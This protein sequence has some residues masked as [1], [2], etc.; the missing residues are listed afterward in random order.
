ML[1]ISSVFLFKR[2]SFLRSSKSFRTLHTFC[3]KL[4]TD[5]INPR[6]TESHTR[7]VP[8][9]STTVDYFSIL[10]WSRNQQWATSFAIILQGVIQLGASGVF[11][12]FSCRLINRQ[13]RTMRPL[14]SIRAMDSATHS[15]PRCQ[16]KCANLVSSPFLLVF[17][18]TLHCVTCRERSLYW[19][20][21]PWM[22]SELHRTSLQ[23]CGICRFRLSFATLTTIRSNISHEVL[24]PIVHR[25]EVCFRGYMDT[26]TFPSDSAV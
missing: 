26:S 22:F 3:F 18:S 12:Q 25:D 4:R 5:E 19:M 8:L 1:T 23:T 16:K 17:M 21:N 10:W 14:L 9:A 7:S 15:M 13:S 6:T 11:L 20:H 24:L 2:S